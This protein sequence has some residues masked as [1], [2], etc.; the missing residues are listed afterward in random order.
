[1][2]LKIPP[3][4]NHFNQPLDT[5]NTKSLLRLLT[6]YRPVSQEERRKKLEELS[7][8]K[9]KGA[10]VKQKLIKKSNNL[11]F[12]LNEVTCLIE[13]KEAKLVVIANDVEP[14]EL[15]LWLPTLCRRFGV[16]FMI[17]KNKATLGKLVHFKNCTCLALRDVEKADS[18]ELTNLSRLAENN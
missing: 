13:R 10:D 11:V 6:K 17:V 15:V 5:S 9:A 18:S 2:R 12:G 3:S 8:Q 16:P 4:V 7:A 1:M 14:I